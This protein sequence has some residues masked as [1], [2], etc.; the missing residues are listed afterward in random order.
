MM[1]PLVGLKTQRLLRLIEVR[2]LLG[3]GEDALR[4]SIQSV[5][6]EYLAR[7]ADSASRVIDGTCKAM[8]GIAVADKRDVTS[9]ATHAAMFV[10]GDLRAAPLCFIGPSSL[11][12][13]ADTQGTWDIVLL[14]A[15]S[16]HA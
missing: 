2:F 8:A 6:R 15:T 10:Y 13:P 7:A 5:I 1:L 3:V 9:Q 14:T 4:W 11:V 16:I 12:L